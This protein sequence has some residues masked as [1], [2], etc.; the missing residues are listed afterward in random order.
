MYQSLS[1][2]E[3]S[4]AQRQKNLW[5]LAIRLLAIRTLIICPA[6]ISIFQL[7]LLH[8]IT[9]INSLIAILAIRPQVLLRNNFPLLRMGTIIQTELKN[10]TVARAHI[11]FM[12][13]SVRSPT[14]LRKRS[15][16]M[17]TVALDC[18]ICL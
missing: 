9:T 4:K 6:I 10:Y 16:R 11:N 17:S 1:D 2:A 7:V 13:H 3:T 12:G 8:V 5:V 18:S 14:N 15:W